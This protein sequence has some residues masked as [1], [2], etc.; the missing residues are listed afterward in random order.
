MKLQGT[1]SAASGHKP[2]AGSEMQGQPLHHENQQNP[3]Q[4]S[5]PST[6][7]MD[8]QPQ[9]PAAPSAAPQIRSRITVVCAECKRLKLKCDRRTPCGSC[10]KR[11]TVS[12]CIYSPA[13][14]EKVDLHSLNNRLIQVESILA[15][16]TAGKTPPPFQSSYPLAQLPQYTPHPSKSRT[17]LTTAASTATSISI[18]LHDLK[19]IWLAHCQLDLFAPGNQAS[20]KPEMPSD[21]TYVKVE[22]SPVETLHLATP[23]HDN[24]IIIDEGPSSRTPARSS[25]QHNLPPL[26]IYYSASV[27]NPRQVGQSTSYTHP[28][29][30]PYPSEF[31]SSFP[32]R[33]YQFPTAPKPFT[34]PSTFQSTTVAP[35]VTPPLLAL[36]PPPHIRSKLLASARAAHPHL[37][38]LIQWA[39]LAEL[40]D[41]EAASAKEKQKALACAIL[42]GVRSGSPSPSPM[43]SW[44]TAGAGV[45]LFACLCY[46]LALGALEPSTDAPVDHAFLYA[47]AGQGMGVWEE[48]RTSLEAKE[49]EGKEAAEASDDMRKPKQADTQKEDMDHL[50]ALLLQV[51]YLLRVGLSRSS[52]ETSSML[53]TA[54]PLIG[55]LVNLA[56]GL[57]L[58]QDP[59]EDVGTGSRKSTKAERRRMIWWEIMF[60]DTFTSDALNHAPLVTP[61]SYTT[62]IPLV[63]QT[64]SSTPDTPTFKYPTPLV[65]C[66]DGDD[67][68]DSTFDPEGADGKP[69]WSTKTNG[70]TKGR[71]ASR[72]PPL[73]LKGKG[74]V[75]STAPPP[76]D[77]ENGFFGVRCRLTRLAQTVTH[78]LSRPGCE[79]C[80]CSNGYTLDQAAKLEAEIRAW[81]A[82]LPAS[83]KLE[84][85]S[86][87]SP[88]D[89]KTDVSKSPRHAALAAELAIVANRMIISAYVPLMRPPPELAASSSTSASASAYS[90]AHPWSPASRATV[91]AAQG[92]VRAARVLQ[93]LVQAGSGTLLMGEFYPLEKAVVDALV[94]CAH[95]GFATGKLRPLLEEVTVALEMLRAMNGEGEFGKIVASLRRRVEAAEAGRRDENLLKR[96]HS[97]LEGGA[98]IEQGGRTGGMPMA[99]DPSSAYG[100]TDD[101]GNDSIEHR[102]LTNSPTPQRTSSVPR[103]KAGD[104]KNARKGS[105]T[106]PAFGIR[107]RGK[108]GAPWIAKRM[109]SSSAKADCGPEPR[110]PDLTPAEGGVS[111]QAAQQFPPS[112]NGTGPPMLDANGYRSRSSSISQAARMQAV[113]YSMQYGG[114]EERHPDMHTSQRRRFS[115]HDQGL[116][117]QQPPPDQG[118][119][120]PFTMSPPA[121]YDPSQQPSRSGSY[122]AP[123]GFEQHRAS[124]NQNTVNGEEMYVGDSSPYPNS[125]APQSSASSP[126]GSTGGHPQTPT[127]ATGSHHPSPPTFG[128]QPSTSSPQSYFHVPSS[129]EA[130][131]DG[132]ATQQQQTMGG[133][134]MDTSMPGQSQ[135]NVSDSMGVPS[136]V[137]STPMY[138]KNQPL[139]YDIK[140][141]PQQ[142]QQHQGMQHYQMASGRTTPGDPQHHHIAMN[143]PSGHT[144]APTPQYVPTQ[145][146]QGQNDGQYWNTGAYYRSQ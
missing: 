7:T 8:D 22:P 20:L 83:L 1:E 48:Y 116:S 44:S 115:I 146:M 13:A 113:D 30:N 6:A 37:P 21:G 64:P 104:K 98:Q 89:P 79:C 76:D 110:P 35:A 109:S 77:V 42:L 142:Q 23:Y 36:L 27:A 2:E 132:H 93:R 139:L 67:E 34:F 53:E 129:Y 24:T 32:Q 141:P 12:R 18:R 107:D 66:L 127:Y 106:Y 52:K 144:W 81:S 41:P 15:M 136:T 82:D 29:S 80:T 131:Y 114:A 19:N 51:K 74:K 57:G 102:P 72:M 105:V 75:A 47:L 55:K 95:S 58:A 117:H 125:S 45:P 73:K 126:Y 71:A 90:A 17:T 49:G 56:R 87:A 108:E 65:D 68:N 123:R 70:V 43:P 122:D 143:P 133:M 61:S 91:D 59:D 9:Q 40:A 140:S 78:R 46:L 118:Q 121:T 96:K 119:V 31:N 3:S 85:T 130:S 28:T 103:S 84:S 100:K 60:Y 99:V 92:V 54:F 50:L 10:T 25:A 39:K 137:P 101:A 11:D 145:P 69:N 63:A 14:A 5:V 120:Q 135:A 33:D 97:V 26:H 4:D 134:S 86:S 112:Q 38:L 94:I 128:P 111:F 138:E 62:K 88:G 16:V 124:F